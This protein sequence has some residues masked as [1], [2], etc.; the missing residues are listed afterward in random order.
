[1]ANVH[2]AE[3]G[4]LRCAVVSL[5]RKGRLVLYAS[6]GLTHDFA[7]Q[8]ALGG[9]LARFLA[10]AVRNIFAPEGAL[11]APPSTVISIAV[12]LAESSEAK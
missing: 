5:K 2:V 1:M 8:P 7:A 6:G 11:T 4:I 9:R 10:Q 3:I 12:T